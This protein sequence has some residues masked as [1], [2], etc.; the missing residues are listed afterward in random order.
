MGDGDNSGSFRGWAASRGHTE[1]GDFSFAILEDYRVYLHGRRK[2]NGEH[3]G[4]GSM[5]QPLLA[6]KGLFRW[7]TLRGELASNPAADVEHV[8]V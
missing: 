3:L 2:A 1:P 8:S 5:S 6:I 7:L 4:W